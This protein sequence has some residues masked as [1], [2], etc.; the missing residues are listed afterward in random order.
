[1]TRHW[2]INGRFLTRPLTGVQRYGREILHALDRLLDSS[3]PLARDLDLELVVPDVGPLELPTLKT[4]RIRKWGR[5]QGHL[6]EQ[7]I[8]PFAVRGGLI[9]LCSTGPVSVRKQVVCVHDLNT[10][11]VPG[12]FSW[13]FRALYRVLIPTL[14]RTAETISTVSHYSAEQLQRF[15]VAMPAKTIV[16]GNGHEHALAWRPAHSAKTRAVAGRNTIAVFGTGS[17][18]KNVGLLLAMAPALA[19]AN[20]RLAIAGATN[21]RVFSSSSHAVT[22]EN[23]VCLGRLSDGEISALL[24]DSLCLAFP[25]LVEGFGLPPLEAMTIG[26]PVVVSNSSCLPEICGDAALYASPTQSEEWLQ[27]FVALR[28]NPS[29][30]AQLIERG[31][32]RSKLYSWQASAQL[33]LDVMARSDGFLVTDSQRA[34]QI[35]SSAHSPSAV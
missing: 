13:R 34:M 4:I 22:F 30:R 3:H 17:P 19:R 14:G 11:L 18:N 32:R 21:L 26:C 31:L 9:S 25:S 2:T 28:E 15:G 1:M 7:A 16:I 20:L 24:R 5:A 23:V 29:M 10:R 6:W 8:L 35:P 12:S 33:Y 27:R